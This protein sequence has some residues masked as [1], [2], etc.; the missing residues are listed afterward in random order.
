M[1]DATHRSWK[2]ITSLFTWEKKRGKWGRWENCLYT[3]RCM[4]LRLTILSWWQRNWS[5]LKQCKPKVARSNKISLQ[6]WGEAYRRV[7]T[8]TTMSDYAQNTRF[9]CSRNEDTAH[10]RALMLNWILRIDASWWRIA[11]Y[12]Y[13]SLDRGM[14]KEKLLILHLSHHGCPRTS[15]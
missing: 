11:D 2:S 3:L 10:T 15:V 14:I 13:N 8:T 5:I 6:T 1:Q 7:L 9:Q 4:W 12:I